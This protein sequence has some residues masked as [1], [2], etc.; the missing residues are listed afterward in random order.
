[1]RAYLKAGDRRAAIRQFARLREVLRVDLGVAPS[2]ETV[3]LFEKALG[4]EGQEMPAP[5][6]RVQAVIARALAPW[7]S[8]S[9]RH[10]AWP[11]PALSAV[12]RWRSAD[13]GLEPQASD[14]H[15]RNPSGDRA[16]ALS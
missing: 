16:L 10:A 8:T 3:A 7:S 4:M 15:G 2:H 6:D 14:G 5:E 9:D 13:R 12:R 11:R 1:M